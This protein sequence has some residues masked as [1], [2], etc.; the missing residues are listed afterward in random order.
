MSAK[1]FQYFMISLI[2]FY[3]FL[4]FISFGI[5]DIEDNEGE[6]ASVITILVYIEIVVLTIFILEI[7]FNIY[8]Y[9]FKFY[10]R[11][12][13]LFFDALIMIGSIVLVVIDL[14][15]E[16]SSFNTISKIV[17]GIF[18]LLR[19]FLLFRKVAVFLKIYVDFYFLGQSIQKNTGYL[20]QI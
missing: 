7:I 10:F 5:N 16:N 1:P 12:R 18:R 4:V 19:I 9:G 6:L 14:V 8:A 13:W 20:F 11:D 15:L 17:R 3:C 2:I